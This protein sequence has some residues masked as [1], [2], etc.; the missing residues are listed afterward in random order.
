MKQMKSA[1]ERIKKRITEGDIIQTPHGILL[2]EKISNETNGNKYIGHEIKKLVAFWT[3]NENDI[4][5][6]CSD[7]RYKNRCKNQIKKKA[8][9]KVKDKVKP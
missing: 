1:E 9:D 4:K 7:F 6:L 2:V 8:W 5:I 3:R